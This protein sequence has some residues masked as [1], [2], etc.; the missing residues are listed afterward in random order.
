MQRRFVGCGRLWALCASI[1]MALSLSAAPALEAV[2]HGPGAMMAEAD[3]PAFHAEHGHTHDMP[4]GHHDS[5]DHDHVC[6]V[7]LASSEAAFHAPPVRTSRPDSM[8]ADGTIRD[9]PRRPPRL[10]MI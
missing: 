1:V 10:M 8:V 5:G 2:E 3:Y 7:V 4:G 9:G 6:A